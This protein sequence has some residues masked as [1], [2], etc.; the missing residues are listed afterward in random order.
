MTV[1]VTREI[2]FV[3]AATRIVR[4]EPVPPKTMFVSATTFVFDERT[5]NTRLL[6]LVSASPMVNG[7][8]GPGTFVPGA[9][10][11]SAIGEIVGRALVMLNVPSAAN[12]EPANAESI[13]CTL[14]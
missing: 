10:A 14:Q 1:T 5:V 12:G 6:A 7:I 13:A 9:M 11:M 4:F 3:R 2:P 8:T